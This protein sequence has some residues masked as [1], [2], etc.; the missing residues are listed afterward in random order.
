[1][2]DRLRRRVINFANLPIKI[3]MPPTYTNIYEIA[4][5]T[6]PSASKIEIKRPEYKRAYITLRNPLSISPNLFPIRVIEEERTIEVSGLMI[7]SVAVAGL[8]GV[9]MWW[10]RSF[11][12]AP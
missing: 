6:I 11:H 10:R 7:T 3:L 4:L 8:D 9:V 12:G 5:K 2:V 1:M